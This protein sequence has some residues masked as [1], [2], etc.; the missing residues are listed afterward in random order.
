MQEGCK[1]KRVKNENADA[2][3]RTDDEPP[4]KIFQPTDPPLIGKEIEWR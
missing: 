4:K 1:N 3:D 2:D